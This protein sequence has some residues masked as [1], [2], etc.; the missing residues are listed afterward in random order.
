MTADPGPAAV[1]VRLAGPGEGRAWHRTKQLGFLAHPAPDAEVD[2]WWDRHFEPG[3]FLGGWDG[4]LCVAT[5]RSIPLE[6]TVPG[7]RAL[8]ASGIASVTVSPT[9]RRR[10]L[11]RRLVHRELELAR[12]R[13]EAVAL[14]T[15]AEHAIY[16]RFGFG[17]A[18]RHRGFAVDV[19]RS[20]R[21]HPGVGELRDGA[22]IELVPPDRLC[23]VGP[24]L[25]ER[26]RRSRPGAITRSAADWGYRSG[27]L[28]VPGATSSP[29]T[30][31][32]HREPGG[33]V[34][35]LLS[36]VTD[37]AY[38]DGDPD[39]TMTV[40]DHLAV[41]PRAAAA[42][43]RFALDVDRVR[44]VVVPNTAPDDPLLLWLV[45]P[46]AA[47]PV[48]GGVEDLWVRVLDGPR[49]FAA[50]TYEVPG[51]VVLD[52]DDPHGHLAGRWLLHAGTDGTGTLT[53]TDLPADLRTDAATL[54]A[55]Y[56]G[57]LPVAQFAA[58]GFVTE[59]RPGAAAELGRV[60]RTS[61]AP[62]CPDEF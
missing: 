20:G 46:R 31:A 45:N 52:V 40:V 59:Q 7:G 48:G 24:D 13:G 21:L 17:H 37:R 27:E 1:D 53:R 19:V 10:G 11:L 49:A 56:L 41:D 6:L 50:R 18:L 8:P 30:T 55:V 16:G 42:L 47:R 62:W 2:A 3:R 15:S 32:V 58:A 25:H 36:Y 5:S 29:C 43:W 38:R 35:A 9:H 22:R 61:T 26:F 51:R 54:G 44:H 57:G 60:L 23:E 33:Q 12:D 14:L 34:S 28:T 4:E 39:A